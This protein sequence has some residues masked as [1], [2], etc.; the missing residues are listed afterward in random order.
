[1]FALGMDVDVA[2]PETGESILHVSI[3]RTSDIDPGTFG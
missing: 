3:S 2:D 1:M